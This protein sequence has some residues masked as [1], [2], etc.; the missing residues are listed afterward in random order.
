MSFPIKFAEARSQFDFAAPIVN[1]VGNGAVLAVGG[2]C[3]A[4]IAGVGLKALGYGQ[5]T[6]SIVTAIPISLATFGC[7]TAGVGIILGVATL[8]ALAIALKNF[9]I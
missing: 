8:V 9:R 4:A 2:F 5:L 3:L 7:V 1:L 6:T